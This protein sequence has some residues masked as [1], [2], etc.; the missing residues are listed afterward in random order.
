MQRAIRAAERPW[1]DFLAAVG[2]AFFLRPHRYHDGGWW[3]GGIHLFGRSRTK[4]G[5]KR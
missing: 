4:N 3:P 5:A 1:R 2:N